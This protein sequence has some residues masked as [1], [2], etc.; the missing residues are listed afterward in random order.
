ML[1][2]VQAN[3]SRKDQPRRYRLETG[4]AGMKS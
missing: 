1:I 2:S 3:Q 4:P